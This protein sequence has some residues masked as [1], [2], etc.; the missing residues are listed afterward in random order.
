M[1]AAAEREANFVERLACAR[2]QGMEAQLQILK[3]PVNRREFE[4]ALYL[5][6]ARAGEASAFMLRFS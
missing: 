5:V 3:R 6:F 4:V 2:D 1:R